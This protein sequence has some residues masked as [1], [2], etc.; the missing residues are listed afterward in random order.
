MAKPIAADNKPIKT[1]LEAGETYYWCACGRSARQPFCD[2]SHKGSSFTPKPFEAEES[3]AAY[4]CMCKL[5]GQPPY[6][7]GS[8]KSIGATPSDRGRETTAPNLATPTPEEPQVAFI[9]PTR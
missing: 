2:G 6:C 5:T 7:D 3:G 4:L 9:V 1:R 8:H